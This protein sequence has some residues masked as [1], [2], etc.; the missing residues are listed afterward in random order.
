MYNSGF[1][2]PVNK[3]QGLYWYSKAAEGGNLKAKI[4]LQGGKRQFQVVANDS[5]KGTLQN[6]AELMIGTVPKTEPTEPPA[7]QDQEEEDVDKPIVPPA[8]ASQKA[9]ILK[10]WGDFKKELNNLLFMH[11]HDIQMATEH[12]ISN[13]K[14]A[15]WSQPQCIWFALEYLKTAKGKTGL[16]EF[17]RVL[18]ELEL[19]E[20]VRIIE[21][22]LFAD[23][24]KI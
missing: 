19:S 20:P 10:Q 18:S 11:K 15:E 13:T 12:L 16:A 1:G 21:E 14:W 4:F 7:I 3:Q 8:P 2:A 22:S 9:D 17:K 23:S 5:N 6:N 24:F